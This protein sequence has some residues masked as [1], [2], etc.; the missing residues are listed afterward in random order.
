MKIRTVLLCVL[1]LLSGSAA[2]IQGQPTGE[3]VIALPNDP[4]GIYIAN[5]SDVTAISATRPLYD[6]LVRYGPNGTIEPGLA[7]TL[8]NQ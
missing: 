3:L 4:T 6:A 8:G 2:L 7:D 1:L 5:A